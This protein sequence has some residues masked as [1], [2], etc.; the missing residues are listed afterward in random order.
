[1]CK[2]ELKK[3]I[4]EYFK[5]CK[6]IPNDEV[7]SEKLG[8][9]IN[10][11]NSTLISLKLLS[12]YNRVRE[13]M[14]GFMKRKIIYEYYINNNITLYNR[15]YLSKVSD[16]PVYII[17]R[18]ETELKNRFNL[19]VKY[20]N[21][22]YAKNESNLNKAVNNSQTEKFK[23][24][25]VF[26]DENSK[27]ECNVYKVANNSQIEKFKNTD[28]LNDNSLIKKRLTKVDKAKLYKE[29][30]ERLKEIGFKCREQYYLSVMNKLGYLPY[31]KDL[32]KELGIRKDIVSS[33]L[34]RLSLSPISMTDYCRKVELKD[35]ALSNIEV[36]KE[37]YFDAEKPLNFIDLGKKLGICRVTVGKQIKFLEENY[38]YKKI[39]DFNKKEKVEKKAKDYGLEF[40]LPFYLE[41]VFNE[42]C[43][44][45]LKDISEKFGITVST[46]REDIRKIKEK[47]N[48]N[49]NIV[50]KKLSP[51]L[52]KEYYISNYYNAIIPLPYKEM[53]KDLGIT[54]WCVNRDLSILN[55]R[56]VK[57]EFK[58]RNGVYINLPIEVRLQGY[59]NYFRLNREIKS[60]R[61]LSKILC[62]NRETI[63]NDFNKYNLYDDYIVLYKKNKGR[64]SN[65]NMRL[66]LYEQI[67]SKYGSVKSITELANELHLSRSTIREDFCK[68]N[69]F[70]KY[71]IESKEFPNNSNHRTYIDERIKLYDEFFSSNKGPI[72]IY[73]L[74]KE[75]NLPRS[76]VRDDFQI[77]HLKYNV[78]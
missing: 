28:V 58:K 14:S 17:E 9:N 63:L 35:K 36:Y 2:E 57:T 43:E 8:V 25:D 40:R 69:L 21:K 59:K 34:K 64:E 76:T 22:Y 23:G 71:R 4:V 39:S 10:D 3:E 16:I 62:I 30:K 31:I 72:S 70:E 54:L 26:N 41:N 15:S 7:L 12:S 37:Y 5:T 33:D 46:V 27:K 49:T 60:I 61:E 45:T 13:F 47:Y 29:E 6:E 20:L 66:N 44:M 32:A 67:F 50:R 73:H 56:L 52:K 51:E 19:T 55:N 11:L 53:A 77:R 24:I 78:I 65:L 48:I 42:E 38:G 18:D 75:L 1:M 74:S 68:L